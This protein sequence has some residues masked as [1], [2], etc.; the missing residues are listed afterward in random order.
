MSK[1]YRNICV[2]N[3]IRHR[4]NA[5]RLEKLAD[6]CRGARLSDYVLRYS[7]EAK[8]SRE[9]AKQWELEAFGSDEYG[10]EQSPSSRSVG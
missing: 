9:L 6:M 10:N 5:N 4:K 1:Q 8:R 7:A 3:S 2:Q